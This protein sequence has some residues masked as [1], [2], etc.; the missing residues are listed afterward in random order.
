[1]ARLGKKGV[2]SLM[3]T[4]KLASSRKLGSST[5]LQPV[6]AVDLSDAP[7]TE[8]MDIETRI[9]IDWAISKGIIN[10]LN[11]AVKFGKEATIFHGEKGSE[12]NVFDIAVKVYKRAQGGVA[13]FG[14]ESERDLSQFQN[15]SSREQLEL[16]TIKEFRNLKKARRF[17][18]PSPTPL[19]TKNN[20][21]FMQ[22]MGVNGRPS[23][24]LG[25]LDHRRGHKRWRTLYKQIVDAVRRYVMGSV[26]CGARARVSYNGFS[27]PCVLGCMFRRCLCMGI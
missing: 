18:V 15:I 21:L 4:M 19:G 25:E 1:V 13:D 9:Q 20:V 27:I 26:L 12:S 17:G 14:E 24:Q 3:Q 11:G 2:S 5:N 10:Q 8:D 22:F 6:T 7:T 23:P 16:W